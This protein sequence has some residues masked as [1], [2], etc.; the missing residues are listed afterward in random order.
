MDGQI[1]ALDMNKDG[2]MIWSSPTSPGPMLSSTLSDLELDDRGHLVKLIPSLSGKIYK[3]QDELIE[4]L[5]MDATSL[6][7]SSFKMQENVVLTG[8]K[9]TRTFGLD[10]Q[11]GEIMYECSMT[12]DCQQFSNS[13]PEDLKDILVVQRTI[14]TVKAH[15]PRSGEQKWNFSVSLHDVNFYPGVN[16]CEDVDVDQSDYEIKEEDNIQLKAVVPEGVLCATVSDEV[17][18]R[19]KFQTPLVDVWKIIDDSMEHVDLFSKNTVPKR[20]TLVDDDDDPDDDDSPELYIGIHK[21]QLYIQE[22]ILMHKQ[23]DEGIRDHMLNPDSS[24]VSFPRVKWK[25]YLVSPSRTPYYDHGSTSPDIPLLTFEQTL[26]NTDA[27]STA[28]AIMNN[29]AEY[30]YDS[31]YYLYA[32][33]VSLDADDPRNLTAGSFEETGGVV[34]ETVVEFVYMNL[35]HWWKEVVFISLVTAFMMNMIIYRP[36][37][38]QMRDNFQQSS[39]DLVEHF[40]EQN[41]PEIEIRETVVEKVVMIEVPVQMN[42]TAVPQTPSTNSEPSFGSSLTSVNRQDS[43]FSSRYLSDFEPVQCLGRGGFGVVFESKNK[44]DDIHYAVKRITMPSSEESRK[45]VKREVK[46]HAKLDHKNVV[47]YFS[48]W[49]ETP[50][51]GWQEEADTWFADADLGTGP[52]PFD[53][54]STDISSISSLTNQDEQKK[55]E[56]NPL[57]PFQGFYNF[58]SE[59]EESHSYSKYSESSFGVEFEKS[60]SGEGNVRGLKDL[61]EDNSG[62]IVFNEVEE[63]MGISEAVSLQIDESDDSESSSESDSNNNS[64]NDVEFVDSSDSS[65][66]LSCVEALDW[67]DKDKQTPQNTKV[68]SQKQKCYMYI[69]MQ[70]CLKDTLRDWLRIN[71]ERKRKGVFSIFSQICGGVEYVHSQ[72]LVHRDLKPSNIYFSPEG[73]IKIGDFGLVTDGELGQSGDSH[74]TPSH[75]RGVE[76]QHTDQVGTQTYM[77][78]EQLLQ[79]PY[80]HKVDIFSM[81]L[82][83]LELLM[84]FSTQMER[85][86]V[87]S[88]AKK[89]RFPVSLSM[90]EEKQLLTRMLHSRPDLRPEAGEILSHSW[91]TG[92]SEDGGFSGR[93][94]MDTLVSVE[95]DT[96]GVDILNEE[97]LDN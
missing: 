83:F 43:E 69:V 20:S 21:K 36:M 66:S 15:L 6:L 95:G 68:K 8:G 19:R 53:P 89:D 84:P 54:T 31:G 67:D 39:R 1:T 35:W 75:S 24:Q 29:N 74:H 96:I 60:D 70:L 27:R 14:Q 23:T 13:S 76:C 17:R 48:T 57:N 62:G 85:I 78:P 88:D 32:E 49:E 16:L 55:P 50:P 93:R 94:R 81:G 10:L 71:T 3:L 51:S 47:R 80:N 9:E 86:N 97:I 37:V 12:G 41:R 18:W 56:S 4:P 34:I 52:T 63:E 5:A 26:E 25:P 22:S 73:I 92:K 77:S 38:Q 64:K 40:R 11:T 42:S 79:K 72:N 44:Y 91:L 2:E 59:I 7:S 87:L 28:L 61:R 65:A 45:K 82:I 30:P 33:K 46:L 58:N 90:S